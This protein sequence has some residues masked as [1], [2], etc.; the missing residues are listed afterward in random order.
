M[1]NSN[2]LDQTPDIGVLDDEL[3]DVD[4][5]PTGL[6]IV[7]AEIQTVGV[8]ELAAVMRKKERSILR[9]LSKNPERLPP[10]LRLPG[11]RK[12]LWLLSDVTQWLHKH[13]DPGEALQGDAGFPGAQPQPAQETH[14]V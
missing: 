8:P 11:V 10:C 3:D 5:L 6:V 7:P 13:R 12:P 14:I 9:D 4:R 2:T 1:G